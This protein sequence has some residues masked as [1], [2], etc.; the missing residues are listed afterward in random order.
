MLAYPHY[1][2]W[3]Q[4]DICTHRLCE[5]CIQSLVLLHHTRSGLTTL[6]ML[7][8]VQLGVYLEPVL[9]MVCVRCIM[10]S[11]LIQIRAVL[12]IT[13]SHLLTEM[14]LLPCMTHPLILILVVT[15]D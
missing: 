8:F 12:W 15:S 3:S 5:G 1:T 14:A 7:A 13:G 4:F 2:I 10:G 9:G 6:V 11:D